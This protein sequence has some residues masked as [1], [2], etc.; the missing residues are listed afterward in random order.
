MDGPPVFRGGDGL[1]RPGGG[2]V[3]AEQLNVPLLGRIPLV[4]ALREG[5][6]EGRPITVV[7]PDGEAAAAF[8]ALADEVVARGPRLRSHPEL[9]IS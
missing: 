6:D 2:A 5:A 8:A 7:E 3:L 4:P 1:R 9:V